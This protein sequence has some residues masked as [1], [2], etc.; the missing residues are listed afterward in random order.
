MK[1][2]NNMSA[3][4]TNKQLLRTENN[5]TKSMER[6][7]SGLK[8][9]HAKDNPAGMAIS[10]KMR[11]QIDGLDRASSNASDGV[12]VLN[13]ADG[14]LNETSSILQ[15][16]RE[17]SVQAAN[18]TNSL[19][20]KQAIQDEINSLREEIDRISTDT[21][22]NSLP[23]LDGSMSRRVY[24]ENATRV[25]ISNF[26]DP[27]EYKLTITRAATQAEAAATPTVDMTDDTTPIG[28]S[29]T[30]SING[31]SV[32]ISDT[33]THKDVYDKLLEA[34]AIGETDLKMDGNRIAGFTSTAYG[35]SAKADIT[36][37]DQTLADA[38]G[39]TTT[40]DTER[41]VYACGTATTV[42]AVTTVTPPAGSDAVVSID[43]TSAFNDT[44]TYKVDGNKVTI[45]DKDGFSMSF[46]AAAG[47][48]ENAAAGTTGEI[49]FDVTDI[50]SMTLHIG[51]NMDQN[52][53]VCIPE[54]SSKS[55]YIDEV[56]VTTVT[57]ADRAITAFD[58]A[59]ARL[60]EVRSQI[61]AYE[62]R[63]E[64]SVSSLDAFG[65]NMTSA[66]SR[67]ADVDM[68]EEMTNYTQ[69]NVLD[70][71]AISVLTQA[72]DLP[73]QVLQLLQ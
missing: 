70:Q 50:G 41:E 22:Y 55:L 8:L 3:V 16:M 37:S 9:N 57:G 61:G 21:E 59:I 29:G 26:V 49:V 33:D 72:N 65:E 52:I 23:L 58:D 45:I 68:A 30:I 10:N 15:R 4:I 73:Q 11:A 7:S 19:A 51:S 24:T 17:L 14:A 31:Y 32:E 36:F 35:A 60:S 64:Y 6:L 43:S 28:A 63:L 67:L 38:L 18:D 66:L 12:S 44:A 42:G 34:S 71:A 53:E 25:S 39:F 47:Y 48:Q 1:I 20:E 27:G 69:Q 46:L 56:D 40:W 5:L 13:I 54:I 62:N 2:N